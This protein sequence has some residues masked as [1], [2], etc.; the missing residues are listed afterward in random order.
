MAS[1]SPTPPSLSPTPHPA[2]LHS[3]P[4]SKRDKR[5]NALSDRLNQLTRSFNQPGDPKVR[6]QHFRGQLAALQADME[7]IRQA[8]TSGSNMQ[9][10]DDSTET[11]HEQFLQTLNKMGFKSSGVNAETMSPKW[12]ANFV[13]DVND[14]MEERDT[15][16]V[17]L[18]VSNL[19]TTDDDFYLFVLQLLTAMLLQNQHRT[20]A[21]SIAAQHTRQLIHSREEHRSLAATIQ[22]RLSQRLKAQLKKLAAEKESSSNSANALQSLS[23]GGAL[24]D[25]SESNPLHLHP[26]HYSLTTGIGSPRRH[27][28]VPYDDDT[29]KETSTRRKPRRRGEVEELLAFGSG[30]NYD[31]PNANGKRK[32]RGAAAADSAPEDVPTPPSFSGPLDPAS[33]TTNPLHE[34]GESHE[35]TKRKREEIMKQVY[36]PVYTMEK[37]FTDKELQLHTNQATLAT[38]RYFSER[39]GK[40]GKDDGDDSSD[41]T[42]TGANTPVPGALGVCDDDDDLEDRGRGLSPISSLT[43][44]LPPLPESTFG[45]STRSNPPRNFASTREM[46]NLVLGGVPGVGMS[47]VNKTGIAPPPPPLRAD[48]AEADLLFLRKGDKRSSAG[49]EN[50]KRQKRG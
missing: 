5:R 38:L 14:A 31:S 45:V 36:A 24:G 4:Q 48:D 20:K 49:V 15:Q 21:A 32:R 37:L 33:P 42:P 28:A 3:Q 11:L 40:E 50:G 10:L 47:Y 34:P 44:G 41:E 26:S 43:R 19:R 30:M 12:F 16:M 22:Q 18:Y 17:L 46:E 8:D 23:I 13:K 6:D 39:A 1:P 27:G 2:H 25:I 29:E 7:L 35:E 9:L